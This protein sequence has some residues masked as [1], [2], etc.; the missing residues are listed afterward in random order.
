MKNTSYNTDIDILSLELK[1]SDKRKREARRKQKAI[2]K[3]FNHK[4][5]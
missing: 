4:V 3:K 2:H 1:T 5:K